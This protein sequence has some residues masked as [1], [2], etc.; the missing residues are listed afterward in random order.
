MSGKTKHADI[1]IDRVECDF[2]VPRATPISQP[3]DVEVGSMPRPTIPGS[4]YPS[5]VNHFYPLMRNQPWLGRRAA[6]RA[7]V[8]SY[9]SLCCGYIKAAFF[10]SPPILVFTSSSVVAKQPQPLRLRYCRSHKGTHTP[11][12]Q[13][14]NMQ[15]W[16]SKIG[17]IKSKIMNC[18]E[19]YGRTALHHST[20]TATIRVATDSDQQPFLSGDRAELWI[21][22]QSQTIAAHA[23]P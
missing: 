2:C 6:Q 7:T 14:S 16:S 18:H 5:H 1:H 4:Q 22:C 12:R 15:R 9:I 8:H 13:I 17:Q 20:C 10:F 3:R 23:E 19:V 21:E 11:K